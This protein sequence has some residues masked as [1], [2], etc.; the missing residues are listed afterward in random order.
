MEASCAYI[1]RCMLLH[2]S[3]FRL[4]RA[5][6]VNSAV[7]GVKISLKSHFPCCWQRFGRTAFLKHGLLTAGCLFVQEQYN[8]LTNKTVAFLKAV[9]SRYRPRYIV[10]ADD[11]VYLR[12][13][14][15]P[16]AVKQWT[17]FKSG[18]PLFWLQSMCTCHNRSKPVPALVAS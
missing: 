2:L 15:L 7:L 4:L 17:A 3:C 14:R 18:T 11:D 13:D 1:S 8:S 9:T 5:V 10:K 12:V 6:H 16:Y